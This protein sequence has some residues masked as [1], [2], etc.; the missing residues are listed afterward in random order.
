M[1]VSS[2]EDEGVGV[3]VVKT[4]MLALLRTLQHIQSVGVRRDTK[5]TSDL[6]TDTNPFFE[7]ETHPVLRLRQIAHTLALREKYRYLQTTFRQSPHGDVSFY[8]CNSWNVSTA[9]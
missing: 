3:V 4:E 1:Q 6:R 2:S 9:G 8:L 7:T 5:G